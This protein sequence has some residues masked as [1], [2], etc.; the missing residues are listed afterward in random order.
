[1]QD[2]SLNSHIISPIF[3]ILSKVLQVLDLKLFVFQY[4]DLNQQRMLVGYNCDSMVIVIGGLGLIS[5][6]LVFL[7]TANQNKVPNLLFVLFVI[8]QA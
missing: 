4:F 7:N 6:I 2:Y 1:M 5:L 3:L 8:L